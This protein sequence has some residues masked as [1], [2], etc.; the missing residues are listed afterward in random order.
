MKATS[1]ILVLFCL[2]LTGC[3]STEVRERREAAVMNTQFAA[4]TTNS[5]DLYR[6]GPGDG[7]KVEFYYNEELNRGVLVRPDGYMSLPL[8]EDV[9]VADETLSEIRK[10]LADRYAGILKKPGILVTLENPGSFKV[11]VGGEV[12]NPGIF[13]LGDGVTA[14]RAIALAGGAKQTAGLASV[15]VIR[16]Q[17]TREPQYLLV[18]LKDSVARLDGRQDIRLRPKDMVFVPKST[19]ASIDEFVELYINQL[20]P[21]QNSLNVTYLFGKPIN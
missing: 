17:G 5:P 15:M 2:A 9:R 4:A 8:I 14:L 6:V 7:L 21:F 20:V 10:S 12:S 3:V 18:N 11:F 1:Q 13:A 19:I 16:D